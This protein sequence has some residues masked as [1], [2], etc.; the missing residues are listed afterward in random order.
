MNTS[1]KAYSYIRFSTPEQ[2]KRDS[3]RRQEEEA[4]NYAQE[5]GFTLDNE[6]KLYDEGVPAYKGENISKGTLGKFLNMVEKG[7][8]ERGSALIVEHFDRL[9]REDP[10]YAF[11][12]FSMII[13]K[14][15][16]LHTLRPR[17]IYTIESI[18][19]NPGQLH[20]SLGYMIRA[21]EESETK[22]KR[23]KAA[24]EEK[25]K[26]VLSR[27]IKIF[28]A[29]CPSWLRLSKD[30]TKFVEI[31]EVS[32]SI[33]LIFKKRRNGKGSFRIANEL[34]LD[35]DVW[36]PSI[37]KR[38][39]S[40]G[41]RDAY[42]NKILRDRK[43]IGEFQLHKFE[44]EIIIK[45][46]Q[47]YKKNKLVTVGKPIKGY[48]P[49]VI[50]KDLFNDVQNILKQ[51][52]ERDG[53]GGG[54][55]NKNKGY[56]LFS[57]VVKCGICGSTMQ[58]VNKGQN[59]F[60]YLICDSFRRKNEVS[61]QVK[62]DQK[63]VNQGIAANLNRREVPVREVETIEKICTAK[64]VRYDKFERI[65]F[66][67]FPEFDISKYLPDHDEKTNEIIEL[68]SELS[69]IE[70]KD[71][72]LD[73]DIKNLMNISSKTDD[74]ENQKLYD[75]E[76]TEKRIAKEQLKPEY[77]KIEQKIK[78]LS[79]QPENVMKQKDRI[80]EVYNFLES[81]KDEKEGIDR[82]LQVK[83]E[84]QNMFY[85]IKIYPLQEEYKEYD[86]IEPGI[87]Q[88]MKSKYIDRLSYKFRNIKLHGLGGGLH[89]KGYIDI[90]E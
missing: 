87:I 74:E 13:N 58:Y 54:G 86:E 84:I 43:V 45:K 80:N 52:G 30:K 14:G 66:E 2:A 7:E 34:N 31:P 33:K 11:S 17:Q 46:G 4:Y 50:T 77:K 55:G 5:N 22:S 8:I 12:Q 78:E 83:Q 39:K 36:K 1:P 20:S 16:S 62:P 25:R 89:L 68:N 90:G 38:N 53:N 61:I 41:W 63:Y 56:N 82:R 27:E 47:E 23:I 42:I 51:N 57:Y 59:K 10:L 32:E 37:T 85:W 18:K 70:D 75:I 21:H 6:L 24:R 72:E 3:L 49:K 81:A 69:A 44:E 19:N 15:I 35:P 88:H 29:K 26:K 40:G 48:Y 64:T 67:N 60:E 76:I 9:S 79:E 28:T 73:S 71:K 65:F